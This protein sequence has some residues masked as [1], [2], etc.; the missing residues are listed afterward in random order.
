MSLM[1]PYTLILLVLW[2]IF[3]VIW[4]L[5]GIPLGPGYPIDF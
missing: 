5:I 3:F 2:I 1:I 4:Y